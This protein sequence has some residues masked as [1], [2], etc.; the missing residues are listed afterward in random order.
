MRTLRAALQLFFNPSFRC[1]RKLV[2]ASE[3]LLEF[4]TEIDG[5]RVNAID[6]MR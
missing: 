5:M 1:V 3:G 4:E 6:L 2:G